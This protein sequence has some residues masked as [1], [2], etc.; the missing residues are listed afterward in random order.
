[1]GIPWSLL[2][3]AGERL[4][5]HRPPGWEPGA[6]GWTTGRHPNLFPD[7]SIF[8]DSY[9]A[10][11]PLS[12]LCHWQPFGDASDLSPALPNP[13]AAEIFWSAFLPQSIPTPSLLTPPRVLTSLTLGILTEAS[14]AQAPGRMT[15]F[16]CG[17]H[18]FLKHRATPA[19]PQ[20]HPVQYSQLCW[21]P[22]PKAHPGSPHCLG[23]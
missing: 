2:G 17:C 20:L 15:V 3:K 19:G 9:P 4:D 1:M 8:S 6:E 22:G 5:A 21:S 18:L 12:A 13:P 11:A 10:W 16:H 23:A 7:S 14:F